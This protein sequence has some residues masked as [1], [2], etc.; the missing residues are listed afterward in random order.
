MFSFY[1]S[2][3]E[4]SLERRYWNDDLEPCIIK[5]CL[6]FRHVMRNYMHCIQKYCPSGLVTVPRDIPK[7]VELMDSMDNKPATFDVESQ[8]VHG[9]CSL[10]CH[11]VKSPLLQKACALSR[12][13][14]RNDPQERDPDELEDPSPWTA[15]VMWGNGIDSLV[16][17]N[18]VEDRTERQELL[19]KVKGNELCGLVLCLTLHGAEFLDCVQ[20]RCRGQEPEEAPTDIAGAVVEDSYTATDESDRTLKRKR[21]I[22]DD[23]SQCIQSY[24]GSIAS[25]V[26]RLACI[27]RSCHRAG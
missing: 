12:C 16:E 27:V 13:H 4:K 5:Y 6:K 11:N 10:L 23:V 8:R 15:P 24:C 18:G 17:S 20:E 22:N 21:R 2:D 14:A 19:G 3:E 9:L 26:G 7:E 25:E 1:S